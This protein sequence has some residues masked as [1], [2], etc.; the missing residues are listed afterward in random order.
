MALPKQ[1]IDPNFKKL[2]LLKLF[3]FSIVLNLF[4]IA[5]G[6]LSRFILPP[7]IPLFFGF[8]QTTE[9]LAP[10]LFI[11]IPSAISL[12]LVIINFYIAL[13][14]ESIYLKKTLAFATLATTLLSSIAVIKI[15]LLVGSI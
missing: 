2:P 15:I 13:N 8:P 7:E 5:L 9:Q 10:S 12:V 11:I 6:L 14:L 4:F 1:I 3:T